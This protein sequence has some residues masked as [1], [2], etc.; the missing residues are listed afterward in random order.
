MMK[1]SE[2]VAPQRNVEFEVGETGASCYNF[3][4]QSLFCEKYV[5]CII[6]VNAYIKYIIRGNKMYHIIDIPCCS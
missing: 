1:L 6:F 5:R 2:Y 3:Q 4:L